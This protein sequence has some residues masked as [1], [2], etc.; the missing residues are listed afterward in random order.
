[1][2]LFSS[3][4]LLA[5]AYIIS[6][7]HPVATAT[8]AVAAS[9][10]E[11]QISQS[12]I[13][14]SA[15][16]GMLSVFPFSVGTSWVYHAVIDTGTPDKPK[17]FEGAITET[18]ISATAHHKNWL[19]H[20]RIS[21]YSTPDSAIE[22]Y[23]VINGTGLYELADANSAASAIDSETMV[24]YAYAQILAWPLEVGQMMGILR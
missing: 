7:M 1:M 23:Y 18:I 2:K 12:T 22:H 13:G 14:A 9:T 11:P 6:D 21:G 5:F 8:L 20:S 24:N 19:F 17:H 15:G 10:A 16:Q 4:V 3:L